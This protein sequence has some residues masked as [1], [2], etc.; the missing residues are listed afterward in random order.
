MENQ[1]TS[2]PPQSPPSKKSFV[3]YILYV[4][5]GLIIIGA[6]SGLVYYYQQYSRLQS[7]IINKDEQV[8]AKQ[9]QLTKIQSEY[10]TLEQ[11]IRTY[12]LNKN[13]T[14]QD[15]IG[16]CLDDANAQYQEL[17]DS[18]FQ[19]IPSGIVAQSLGI[20]PDKFVIKSVS[21]AT[22]DLNKDI[23]CG[24]KVNP[25]V[26]RYFYTN[27]ESATGWCKNISLIG[28]NIVKVI[29]FDLE[30]TNNF[31]DMSL[32]YDVTDKTTNV[33]T[34]A[35]ARMFL[36]FS[37][38]VYIFTPIDTNKKTGRIVFMVP[39]DKQ[40]FTLKYPQGQLALSLAE[41]SIGQVK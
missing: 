41:K 33:V 30:L 2:I 18:F 37:E 9:Q 1:S 29:G 31:P 14:C 32:V 4:L 6:I 25:Q 28:S 7:E 36:P 3:V 19:I 39:Q 10:S 13:T 12:F 17:S 40:S 24:G 20:S 35:E 27:D 16:K 15:S 34:Q 38:G 8:T 11:S 23:G 21:I 22:I 26:A 5:I